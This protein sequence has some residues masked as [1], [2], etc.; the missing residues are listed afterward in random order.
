MEHPGGGENTFCGVPAG[1]LVATFVDVV[2]DGF[3]VGVRFAAGGSV[4]L[5]G[6]RRIVDGGP[7]SP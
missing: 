6:H 2:M 4:T 3:F 1:L 5:P 7:W